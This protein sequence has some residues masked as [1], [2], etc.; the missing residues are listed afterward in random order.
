MRQF[1]VIFVDALRLLRARALFWITLGISLLAGVTYLSIGFSDHGMTVM[2]GAMEL[3]NP[4]ITRGSE[5]AGMVYFGVFAMFIVPIWLSWVAVILALINCSPVFPEF[6]AEGAAGTVLSKPIPR[7]KLFLFKYLC[8]LLF[9]LL[10]TSA[11]C[12]L[13]FFAMRWRV[14]TWNLSV[15]WAVPLVTLMFSYLWSVMAA[16]G[17]KTKSVMA[18]MLA[19]LLFWLTCWTAKLSEEIAWSAAETGM[20]GNLQLSAGQQAKWKQNQLLMELPYRILPKTSDTVNLL[21]RFVRLEGD[22]EFSLSE[23]VSALEDGAPR[24]DP[25]IDA[26]VERRS[27]GF[28]LG[29]SLAFELVVLGWGGWMFCRRDF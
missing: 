26:A 17:V 14:G 7:W 2:F 8:G 22:R 28:I 21:Q 9:A 3:E 5:M 4:A 6:M 15:F 25:A 29:S 23:I 20:V 27:T 11:F 1:A 19:S 16:V 24:K 18:S 12:L 10:Q 13:V